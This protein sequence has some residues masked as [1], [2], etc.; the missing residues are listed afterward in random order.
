MKT[1]VT[2]VDAARFEE[3]ILASGLPHLAQK[4]FV[5]VMAAKGRALY[6]AA[7]KR[8]GRVD[9][10][11]FTVSEGVREPHCGEFGN[12]RQQLDFSVTEAEILNNFAWLL[13]ALAEQ[14]AAEKAER[15]APA[16]KE[17]EPA[18][19]SAI[20]T[21]AARKA[22]IERVAAEKGVPVSAA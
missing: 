22:L 18:G 6:V 3:L 12:V 7:T 17:D 10:S 9:L 16:P 1:N 15:K 8:V 4:G 2:Y 19:W 21:K 5:K 11:G 20:E 14:P 13:V